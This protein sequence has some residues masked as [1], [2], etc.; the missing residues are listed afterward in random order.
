M[1]VS[2][3]MGVSN[4]KIGWGKIHKWMMTG[5]TPVSGNLHLVNVVITNSLNQQY[6]GTDPTPG[7][8]RVHT[9][10]FWLTLSIFDSLQKQRCNPLLIVVIFRCKK[11]KD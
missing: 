2:I 7:H 10:G 9:F 1:V 8:H 4:K 11:L 5:G 6:I 3:V